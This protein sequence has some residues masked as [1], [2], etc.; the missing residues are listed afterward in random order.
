MLQGATPPG[1]MWRTVLV[2]CLLCRG[3]GYGGS[4]GVRT[5]FRSRVLSL[6]DTDTF[7]VVKDGPLVFTNAGSVRL[8]NNATLSDSFGSASFDIVTGLANFLSTANTANVTQRNLPVQ[9]A[10]AKM[11]KDI[12][13]LDDVA[14][15]TPQLT[16]LELV[17]LF[18]TVFVSAASPAALPINV[19]EVLVPSMA[20][21]SAAV[22]ISAEYA[23]KVAVSNG[24]EIAALAM[25]AAAESESILAQAERAKAILPL[26][27]G[28]STTASALAL[29]I[30]SLTIELQSKLAVPVVAEY[31]LICPLVAVLGA[32]IAGLASQETIVLGSRAAGVGNR[33]FASSSTVGVTW[34]SQTE[35]VEASAVKGTKRWT[36]FAYGVLPAPL[37]ATL[38]PGVL[39][40]K[41]VV[42]AAVAA[43]QA[44]YY[45]STAEFAIAEASDAV[46]LKS[47]TAAVAD[48]YANQGSRAGAVLPFTSALGGLCA[49]AS[50][51]CV[52][53]LPLVPL[54]ELQS[55]LAV[56]FP[57]AAAMFAAAAAV[58]KARCEVD[59]AAAS[60]AA[61]TGLAQS[62]VSRD[63]TKLVLELILCTLATTKVRVAYF[64]KRARSKFRVKFQSF[65]EK[66]GWKGSAKGAVKGMGGGGSGSSGVGGREGSD[67][68]RARQLRRLSVE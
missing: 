46:A 37:I 50:A 5:A 64:V 31:F 68:S 20:A 65:L 60:A 14:G 63:P 29:L 24:K 10:I 17:L 35:Q 3:W 12:Q 32:A 61:S 67:L 47:R 40:F 62:A 22:G 13:L 53:V 15:S 36:S 11:T 66:I 52:E 59:A 55:L 1:L 30:P 7:R 25:Q 51:A 58:S 2:L 44:A 21:L 28:I 42:C 38:F 39:S 45:L 49:A 19:V 26:C 33:R 41:A 34:K 6:R 27:V 57:A 48:T 18:A 54:W 56:L 43:A 23:G 8:V 4:G 16:R 9:S